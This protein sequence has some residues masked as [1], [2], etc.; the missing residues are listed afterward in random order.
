L[1]NSSFPRPKRL[2]KSEKQE[3]ADLGTPLNPI[4]S[5]NSMVTQGAVVASERPRSPHSGMPA[6]LNLGQAYAETLNASLALPVTGLLPVN[7]DLPTAV[8]TA[9]GSLP[10]IHALRDRVKDELPRFDLR[11]F[12]R[13]EQYALAAAQAH[14]EF[15]AASAPSE[16]LVDLN[17]RAVLTRDMLYK[18][19]V[20]LAGRGLINGD[21]VRDFKAKVGYKNITYDLLGL[22]AV[23]RENWA[24]ISSRTAIQAHELEQAEAL[25]GRLMSVLSARKQTPAVVVEAS[26]QR[27]R[28]FTLFVNAYDQV[29][30]A[31][32]YLLWEAGDLERVAPS[33]YGGRVVNRKK[34]DMKRSRAAPTTTLPGDGSGGNAVEPGASSTD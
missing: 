13:L 7:I 33:L 20:A 31:L 17:R 25:V 3:M 19:A 5:E 4:A 29:R 8:N 30:R 34:G 22:V 26:L 18:D 15:L 6:A 14:G 11:H 1:R 10:R 24:R 9:V 21:R 16:A 2:F 12:E 28:N 23:L 32:S 27:Q